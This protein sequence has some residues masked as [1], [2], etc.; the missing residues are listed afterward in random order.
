MKKKTISKPPFFIIRHWKTIFWLIIISIF[1]WFCIIIPRKEI[2]EL[3][4]NG[5][6][7]KGYL[8]EVKTVGSKGTIR[9]FYRFKVSNSIYEGFYDNDTLKRF[10]S[11][12][13]I[14]SPIDPEVNRAKK[15]VEDW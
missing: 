12:E 13:I 14:F 4:E 8:Y 3:T 15:F 1:L 7:V 5:K 2:H 11:I 6:Q 10:D 9:G